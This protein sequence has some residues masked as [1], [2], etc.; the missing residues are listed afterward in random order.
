MPKVTEEM[1]EAAAAAIYNADPRRP[2]V[3]THDDGERRFCDF[4]KCDCSSGAF[5]RCS[6]PPLKE[7]AGTSM[8]RVIDMRRSLEAALD[9]F[10]LIAERIQAGQIERA[11]GTAM[12][13]AKEA[14]AALAATEAD[15]G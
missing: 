11:K 9:D 3:A 1:V 15:H 8:L 6:H 5:E 13:G 4:P 10:E 2:V 7:T 14:R 12:Q